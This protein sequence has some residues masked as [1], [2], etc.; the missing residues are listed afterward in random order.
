VQGSGLHDAN[1]SRTGVKIAQ[2]GFLDGNDV[3]RE[4]PPSKADGR[5]VMAA[6]VS[7]YLPHQNE[8]HQN[9]CAQCGQPIAAPA[10]FEDGPHR[11]AYLW[12]CAACGYRFESVAFFA[13]AERQPDAIAA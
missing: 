10:W 4:N 6:V 8:P 7:G 13:T 9:P 2:R 12:Q 11:T 1:L 5:S 3:Q